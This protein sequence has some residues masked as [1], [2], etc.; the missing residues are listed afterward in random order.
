M[1]LFGT[2][3]VRG[4]IN[5][6]ITSESML[7]LGKA[8]GTTIPVGS[9]VCVASDPR[10]SRDMIKSSLTAGVLS[11]GVNVVDLGIL[12]TPC[13]AYLTRELKMDSGMMI[14]ASHNPP[15]FNGVKLWNPS[16][17]GYSVEQEQLV[18]RIYF[19]EAFRTVPWSSLGHVKKHENAHTHYFEAVR[20]RISVDTSL[21]VVV[22]PGNGAASHIASQLFEK[23]GISVLPVNDIPDGR[24]P[25]RPS[26]PREDTLK[27][28]I[29]YLRDEG[30][31]LAV[32]F[33]GD[34]DR[35]VFCD[36]QG[37]LGYNE[38]IAYISYLVVKESSRKVVATTVETGRLLDCAAGKAGGTVERGKVGDV[39]VAQLLKEKNACIGVEQVGV[40]ILPEI[41]MHPD[42]LYAALF[43]LSN[44][45][46]PSQ[47]RQF[48]A[49]LP[50]MHFAKS[51]VRC[52]NHE[53]ERVMKRVQSSLSE[54][55]PSDVNM[56][57]GIRIEFDDSWLLIRP[58][59]TEPVIR[60]LCESE[61]L[62]AMETFLNE[63]NQMVEKALE[64]VDP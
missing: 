45:D 58:S 34:A 20:G 31:D 38:M 40:Y 2:S 1:R 51:S 57:D 17:I 61:S 32:C 59:G 27:E 18:E 53:K 10:L 12:P 14:T 6:E 25:T 13:L 52:P 37:F 21:K 55:S 29:Q 15:E 26:E 56:L 4:V 30:G 42:S 8:V 7:N 5:E 28:T 49:S 39:H 46:H 23:M 60:V 54:L 22:D 36:N 63:G 41:G 16:T 24:F 9:Q 33:D 35:V 47:I 3:G 19:D 64:K 48:I 11:T 43:L 50:T 62:S 44:I